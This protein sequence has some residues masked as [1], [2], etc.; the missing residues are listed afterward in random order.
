[1]GVMRRRDFLCTGAAAT[2]LGVATRRAWAQAKRPRIVVIGGGFAG[3]YSALALKRRQPDFDVVLVDPDERYITCPLSNEV[4]VG[5]RTLDSLTV[6]RAGLAH[7]GVRFVCRRAVAIDAPSRRVHLDDGAQLD[8]DRLIVA[9]GIRFL[10][11]RIENYNEVAAQRMPHAWKAGAQTALLAAQ[12][13]AM[14]DGGVV[15]I[16][17]PGGLMRCPP[18]PY[19]RASLIAGYL[20]AH[21]PR[22]KVLILD[23]NNHFPRMDRFSE[24]W[25]QRYPGMIEWIAS[26]DGGMVVRVDVEKSTL[27]TTGDTHRVDV[28]NVIP[29]QAPD[30]IAVDAGLASGHGWCP[31]KPES[32]ESTLA[33]H[34]HVIGDACIA[35]AMPKAASA[36]ISQARQCVLAIEASLAG[37]E[38][39]PPEF[40]SVCYS[41]LAPDSG[42]A[43]HARFQIEDGA[44]RPIAPQAGANAD[45]PS[46]LDDAGHWYTGIIAD[47]FGT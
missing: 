7:A 1:M 43:I 40:D 18:G 8:Y 32:F 44:I 6:T 45:A 28:A 5:L 27:Y 41:R 4:L 35:G 25:K 19:E 42:L 33:G 24:F 36:A 39:P 16:S 11:E 10:W 26:T 2:L 9:P 37:R 15:A 29:P 17:V 20:K 31:V 38:V 30:R 46:P 21:K 47:S 23:A 3:S 12:L 34:V 14:P 13:R 22:S